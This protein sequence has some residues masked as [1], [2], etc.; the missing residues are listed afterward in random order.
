MSII[1]KLR[2]A[3]RRRKA[4]RELRAMEPHVLRDIGIE[5]GQIDAAV[6]GLLGEAETPR[7]VPEPYRR[8]QPDAIAFKSAVFSK[9]DWPYDHRRA[10]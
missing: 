7:S 4:A 10:A 6:S 5:P 3:Y 1:A 2:L 8:P 9:V